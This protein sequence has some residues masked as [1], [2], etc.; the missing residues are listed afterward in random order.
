VSLLIVP[1]DGAGTF[2][3]TDPLATAENYIARYADGTA[4]TFTSDTTAGAF[5]H[6]ATGIQLPNANY[7]VGLLNHS[8][9]ALAASGNTIQASGTYSVDDV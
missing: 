9:A 7:K 6:V 8:G 2:P 3:T 1:D 4:A 5:V